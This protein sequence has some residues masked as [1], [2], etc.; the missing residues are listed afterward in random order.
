MQSKELY[1]YNSRNNSVDVAIGV[2]FQERYGS[3]F[4]NEQAHY[5]EA[6]ALRH[7]V[8]MDIL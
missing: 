5:K 1:P 3:L 7:L 8:A 6:P 2:R 4:S